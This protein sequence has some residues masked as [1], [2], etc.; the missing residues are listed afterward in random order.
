MNTLCTLAIGLDGE[1]IFLS[2]FGNPTDDS[3]STPSV[4]PARAKP[5]SFAIS[6]SKT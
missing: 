6:S 2:V 3:M 4:K 5:L 1:E